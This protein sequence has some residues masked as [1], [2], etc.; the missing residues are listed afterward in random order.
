MQTIAGKLH[1]KY[2]YASFTTPLKNLTKLQINLQL[3]R[4]CGF[5]EESQDSLLTKHMNKCPE[6]TIMEI[7]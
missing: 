2:N 3:N 4:T 5:R 6:K 1:L 7:I